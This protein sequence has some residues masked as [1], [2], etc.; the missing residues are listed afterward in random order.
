M[1]SFWCYAACSFGLEAVVARELTALGLKEV[2]ARDARVY[3]RAD[4]RGVARACLHLSAADR[5]YLVLGEFPAA[6][7]DELFEGVKALPW[8]DW[9]AKDA[10]FPVQADAVRSRL[11]SVPD[12]QSVGKKAVV[13]ALSRAYGLRFFR[14]NGA[15]V[16]LYI[17]ILADRASV[18]VNP[19]GM[20]LNRRG[21]RVKN[22][23]APLRETL[24][25]GM[26]HLSRWRDRPFYD[27]MCGSG[28][29]AIEAARKA[30]CIAPGLSREF[31]ARA[32]GEAWSAVF[33]E[34]R[35]AARAA[36]LPAAPGLVFARDIDPKMVEMARF[37]A[38]RAGVEGDISFA[39]A[40]VRG[41]APGEERGTIFAN[42]PYAIRLGEREET[43]A[44][45]AAMGRA[46]APLS[47]WRQYYICADDAFERLFGRRADKTRK[48]YNGN[49][50]CGFY[51]YFRD[52]GGT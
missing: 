15:E 39:V 50:R 45:Y 21:Y 43:R 46:L 28:T 44:L 23:P 51:Q 6:S 32:W 34:E 25:A 49:I 35:E 13:E 4:E 10:R 19:C 16:G 36:V 11:K 31:A 30:R 26:L 18:C 37:H 27:L 7:F 17:S 2:K 42:P 22:G 9:L 3:F 5:V 1:S 33:A 40:D 24:A 8:A 38:R 41:F 52:G 20:G 12:I 29:I 47:G 48:L 14:E